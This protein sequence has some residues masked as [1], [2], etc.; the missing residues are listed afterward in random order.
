MQ[1]HT[2]CNACFRGVNP[3][4]QATYDRVGGEIDAWIPELRNVG[5]CVT[6][7]SPDKICPFHSCFGLYFL[8]HIQVDP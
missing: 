6:E 1:L 7:A 5:S 3:A 8:A 4:T 2:L